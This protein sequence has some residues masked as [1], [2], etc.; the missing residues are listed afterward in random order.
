PARGRA[1]RAR[2]RRRPARLTARAPPGRAQARPLPLLPNGVA[3]AVAGAAPATVDPEAA[4]A[5]RR[6]LTARQVRRHGARA[7]DVG[8]HPAHA[9]AIERAQGVVA[10]G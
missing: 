2:R 5:A 9:V 6:T 7:P 3:A 1:R 4:A 8:A 10:D